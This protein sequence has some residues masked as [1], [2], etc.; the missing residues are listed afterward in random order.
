MAQDLG[1]L[2]IELQLC[3][4]TSLMIIYV[5][6]FVCVCE[7]VLVVCLRNHIILEPITHAHSLL[8]VSLVLIVVRGTT[9]DI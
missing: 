8:N 2:M 4:A 9:C 6:A 3:I 1:P 7:R 5:F